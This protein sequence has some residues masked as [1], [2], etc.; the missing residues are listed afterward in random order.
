MPVQMAYDVPIGMDFK[1]IERKEKL[2]IAKSKNP[3]VG[4]GREKWFESFN[5]VVKPISNKPAII[6]QI[7]AITNLNI[8]KME[9]FSM[10]D[11]EILFLKFL[12]Y[13]KK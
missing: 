5:K 7:Q 6:R 12:S 3:I 9:F 1:L 10:N 11:F 2:K 4:K 8:L 13:I